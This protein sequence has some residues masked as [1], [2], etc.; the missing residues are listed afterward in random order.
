MI[1]RHVINGKAAKGAASFKFSDIL[2]LSQSEG[3]GA[4]YAQPLRH[5]I[6][7]MITPLI[8]MLSTS[9]FY[10]H[11]RDSERLMIFDPYSMYFTKKFLDFFKNKD[12]E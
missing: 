10:P 1:Y 6:F 2:P 11:L 8:Y 12:P 7:F 5:I 4:D 9:K 3:R